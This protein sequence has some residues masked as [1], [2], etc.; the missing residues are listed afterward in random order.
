MQIHTSFIYLSGLQHSQMP[1]LR[2]PFASCY[3]ETVHTSKGHVLRS[4][5]N[6]ATSTQLQP[7]HRTNSML[8]TLILYTICTGMLTGLY[9]IVQI[10]VY[11]ALPQP[12]VFNALYFSSVYLNALLASLNARYKL[13]DEFYNAGTLVFDTVRLRS[14]SQ[15][16]KV[17]L[18]GDG[19]SNDDLR[20]DVTNL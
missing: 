13:R 8:N 7:F 18:R 9:A 19:N 17:H 15:S 16:K 6:T 14:P 5:W 4:I 2:H 1:S 12:I 11:A 20:V 3:F 10:V